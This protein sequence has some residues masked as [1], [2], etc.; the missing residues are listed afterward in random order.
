MTTDRVYRRSL[1]HD[2]A[3]RELERCAGSQFDPDVV[4]AL[5]AELEEAGVESAADSVGVA[6]V[7]R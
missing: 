7:A 2:A 3:I 5:K 6:A 4:A 1:P